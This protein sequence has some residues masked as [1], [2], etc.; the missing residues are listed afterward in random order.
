MELNKSSLTST[1]NDMYIMKV[2]ENGEQHS[3]L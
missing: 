2:S 1:S 3:G